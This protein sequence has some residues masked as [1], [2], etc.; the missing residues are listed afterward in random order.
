LTVAVGGGSGGGGGGSGTRKI[1]SA[2]GN[3]HVVDSFLW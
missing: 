3:D 2:T 1:I